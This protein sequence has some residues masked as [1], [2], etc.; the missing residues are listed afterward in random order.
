MTLQNNTELQQLLAPDYELIKSSSQE[1]L[2]DHCKKDKLAKKTAINSLASFVGYI[3]L[4]VVAVTYNFS[5]AHFIQYLPDFIVLSLCGFMLIFKR[6]FLTKTWGYVVFSALAAYTYIITFTVHTAEMK[7]NVGFIAFMLLSFFAL[8]MVILYILCARQPIKLS[9]SKERLHI[10][11]RCILTGVSDEEC[12]I[13]ELECKVIRDHKRPI[14]QC[15]LCGKTSS[16]KYVKLLIIFGRN[17]KELEMR[18]TKILHFI[19]K[20]IQVPVIG[21]EDALQ[22]MQ[23]KETTQEKT[24][25]LQQTNLTAGSYLCYKQQ[26]AIQIFTAASH[27]NIFDGKQQLYNQLC[28]FNAKLKTTESKQEL[29]VGVFALLGSIFVVVFGLQLLRTMHITFS[30]LSGTI[31]LF[32]AITIGFSLANGCK[33]CIHR[34]Q[35]R[36]K[37]ESQVLSLTKKEIL[38]LISQ[39]HQDTK[40]HDVASYV[41]ASY[42]HKT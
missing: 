34:K 11:N 42:L 14:K 19:H 10:T 25:Q 33:N 41:I 27:K 9:V 26:N 23:N 3:L 4:I 20:Y 28:E 18:G 40:L 17:Y 37:Y 6:F 35:W 30:Q 36:D 16:G 38:L 29:F 32:L 12:T 5:Q 22:V 31:A 7:A 2:I 8:T 39:C 1:L 21:N 15:W 13:T 24:A